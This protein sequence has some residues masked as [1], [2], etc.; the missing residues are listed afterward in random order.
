MTRR[1]FGFTFFELMTVFVIISVMAA[2]A[3]PRISR[4][5]RQARIRNAQAVVMGE[6]SQAASTAARRRRPVVVE[7]L[8]GSGQL[9]TRL[10][11]AAGQYISLR[12]LGPTSEYALRDVQ[13]TSGG[14]PVDSVIIVPSSLAQATCVRLQIGTGSDTLVRRVHLNRTG[15][16]RSL[17]PGEACP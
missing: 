15:V 7:W 14:A 6:L 9:A 12:S 16:P 13:V 5:V 17:R 8:P 4:G 2:I 10:A 11:G 3:G 1:R